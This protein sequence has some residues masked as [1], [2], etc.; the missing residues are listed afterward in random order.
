MATTPI[1]HRDRPAED[2]V[3]LD[4]Y[5][6]Y[7]E[8]YLAVL[9]TTSHFQQIE[10]IDPFAGSGVLEDQKPGSA[11]VAA[12]IIAKMAG[13]S[14]INKY[15]KEVRLI[16]N[17]LDGEAYASLN[18]HLGEYKFSEISNK[19]ANNLVENLPPP[20]TGHRLFFIDPYGFTQIHP[21][22]LLNILKN[23]RCETFIFM[24]THFGYRFRNIDSA[25]SD[26]LL[27]LGVNIQL[28]SEATIIE[29]YADTIADNLQ[30]TAG[31]DAFA[32]RQMLKRYKK[33]N[34]YCLFFVTHNI[35]GAD[36]FLDAQYTT[37]QRDERGQSLDIILPEEEQILNKIFARETYNNVELFMRALE[38][39]ISPRNLE[40]ILKRLEREATP[41]VFIEEL[42][43]K[44]RS[45]GALYI[46]YDYHRKKD[47]RLSITLKRRS[48]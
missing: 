17:D 48:S 41:R 4:L 9:L 23:E 28:L 21:D 26:T 38:C 1:K 31:K 44:K 12:R 33:S 39:K 15:K 35:R 24:P 36:K 22:N 47:I 3:K 30:V 29:E 8:S 42:S 5:E 45:G 10:I 2:Y 11:L 43:P 7:L 13:D 16:L 27:A 14:R 34:I 46:K 25:I 18:K 6:R 20:R 40:D 37:W 19:D 32:Y